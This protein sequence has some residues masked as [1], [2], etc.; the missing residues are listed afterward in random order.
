MLTDS[1]QAQGD[2]GWQRWGGGTIVQS[3]GSVYGTRLDSTCIDPLWLGQWPERAMRD[4]RDLCIGA[5]IFVRGW[6]AMG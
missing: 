5:T 4:G 3:T 1:G 6:V 2:L